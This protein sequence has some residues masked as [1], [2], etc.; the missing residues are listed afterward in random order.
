MKF[1]SQEIE[2]L[3]NGL[4]TASPQEIIAWAVNSF[5]EKIALSSS[6]QT[7]SVPLLH[8]IKE[9]CPEMRKRGTLCV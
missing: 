7:Q 3:S 5:P 4:E 9:I 6:F 2:L 1:T 8:M